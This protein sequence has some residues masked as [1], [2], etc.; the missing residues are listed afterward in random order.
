VV[1]AATDTPVPEGQVWWEQDTEGCTPTERQALSGGGAQQQVGSGRRHA[2]IQA[3]GYAMTDV[4]VEIPAV[5]GIDKVVRLHPAQTRLETNRI[6]ILDKVYF[7]FDSD[8]IDAKSYELLNEVSAVVMANPS[9][10][11]VEVA[12]HTDSDG[13]DAY[14]LELSDRR[15]NAVRNYLVSRGVG[16]G[17]IIAT[18]YGEIRPLVGNDTPEGKAQNRRVEFNLLDAP[19][20]VTPPPRK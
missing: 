16:A 10:G 4:V 7:Q 17:R 5:G 14:N 6:V 11:R 3:A 2:F 8:I 15:A 1:D 19:A 12:G 9:L 13:A 18:G 20:G